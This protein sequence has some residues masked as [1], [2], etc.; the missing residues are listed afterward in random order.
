MSQKKSRE[1]TTRTTNTTINEFMVADGR[2]SFR[3]P[4]RQKY[5]S[6]YGITEHRN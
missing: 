5:D 6:H 4:N 2:T 3:K 1:S